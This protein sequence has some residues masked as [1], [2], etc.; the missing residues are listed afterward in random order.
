MDGKSVCCLV[1]CFCKFIHQC[2]VLFTG[3]ILKHIS[4]FTLKLTFTIQSLFPCFFRAQYIQAAK[5]A[6]HQK[7]IAAHAGTAEFPKVRTFKKNDKSTNS[8]YGDL[9]EA[10][11]W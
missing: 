6:Y 5:S 7:M 2:Q 3:I 11:H 10:E 1:I 9:S 4:R 8:V